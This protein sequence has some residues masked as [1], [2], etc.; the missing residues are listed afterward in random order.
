LVYE[1]KVDTLNRSWTALVDVHYEHD[2]TLLVWD[3]NEKMLIPDEY[4]DGIKGVDLREQVVKWAKP[5]QNLD[6]IAREHLEDRRLQCWQCNYEI[7]GLT[8]AR[9]PE[10]GTRFDIADIAKASRVVLDQPSV[11]S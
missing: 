6:R 10:C 11:G 7:N 8:V 4:L 9:C 3:S 1:D 5:F 2:A